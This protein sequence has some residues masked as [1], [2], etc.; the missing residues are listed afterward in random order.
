MVVDYIDSEHANARSFEIYYQCPL[1]HVP[2]A[3]GRPP[4]DISRDQLE[5]LSSLSFSW[6]QIASILGVSRMTIFRRR[7]NFNIP[8]R[9]STL[10]DEE[11]RRLIELWK[12]EMPNIGI[13][14][15]TGEKLGVSDS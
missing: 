3:R 7:Q 8:R 14:I 15:I 9:T 4:F 10:C 13:T 2:G 11:L 5:Y 1:S 6:T 12:T